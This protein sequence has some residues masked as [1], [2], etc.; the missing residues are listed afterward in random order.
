[1]EGV[2]ASKLALLFISGVI[3]EQVSSC[4]G[5]QAGHVED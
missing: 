3:F 5:H 1:M 2:H 4:T